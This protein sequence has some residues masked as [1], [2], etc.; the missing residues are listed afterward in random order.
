[1]F[2]QSQ[3]LAAAAAVLFLI[4][5]MAGRRLYIGT[6]AADATTARLAEGYLLWFVPALALQFVLATM[7]AALRGS[8]AFRTP[9]IV[10]VVTVAINIVLAPFLIFGWGTGVAFG[11]EGA[12]IASLVAIA[13]GVAWLTV[14]F[15]PSPTRSCASPPPT[16]RPGRRRGAGSSPSA[17]RPAPSSA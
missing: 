11:V 10:Q 16:R 15:L 17:C 3:W 4:V 9:M 7:A 8:G 5:A 12:A 1:M 14:Q 6:L 2:H 13:V